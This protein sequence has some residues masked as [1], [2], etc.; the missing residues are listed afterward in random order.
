MAPVISLALRLVEASPSKVRWAVRNF[1]RLLFDLK[2]SKA[3]QIAPFNLGVSPTLAT[4]DGYE[5]SLKEL[6]RQPHREIERQTH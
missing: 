2:S 3:K 4:D 6:E 5:L 1:A